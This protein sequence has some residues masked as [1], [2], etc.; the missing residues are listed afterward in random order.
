MGGGCEFLW[1]HRFGVSKD[2][3]RSSLLCVLGEVLYSCDGSSGV[4]ARVNFFHFAGFGPQRIL[5]LDCC[6]A[7]ALDVSPTMLETFCVV[8]LLFLERM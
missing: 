8:C 2:N 6:S 1:G 7:F 4:R 3:S 5:F